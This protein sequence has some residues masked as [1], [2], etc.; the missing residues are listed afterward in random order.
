MNAL[1]AFIKTLGTQEEETLV[2]A[3][4]SIYELKINQLDGIPLNLKEYEGKY[5]LFVNVASKCGFTPQYKEL[6]TLYRTYQDQLVVIGV[7]SNQFGGQEPGDA[8]TIQHFCELNY[9][10]TFPITE[11][12]KV[13]GKKKH[14]IYQWLTE[15]RLNNK[16]SSSVKWNFQKYLVDDKGKLVDTYLS[17]TSP[18][19][20]KITKHLNK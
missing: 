13:R 7:P 3:G 6:E 2:K 1:E 10:V 17:L 5:L 8:Q 19:S 16:R 9:G 14:P 4:T 11:K 12:V 15:K 20:K 18:L